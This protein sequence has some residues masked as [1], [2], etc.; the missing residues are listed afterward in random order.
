MN[1]G[2]SFFRYCRRDGYMQARVI[3]NP[4]CASQ[5]VADTFL[6]RGLQVIEG[7]LCL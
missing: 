1:R 7:Y 5:N 4:L 6:P 3:F 2:G